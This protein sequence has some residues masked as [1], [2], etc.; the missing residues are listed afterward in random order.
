ML[1]AHSRC[2]R[3]N[4]VMKVRVE[5]RKWRMTVQPG[6]DLHE[7]AKFLLSGEVFHYFRIFLARIT[8]SQFKGHACTRHTHAHTHTNTHSE[9]CWDGLLSWGLYLEPAECPFWQGAAIEVVKGPV[10]PADTLSCLVCPPSALQLDKICSFLEALGPSRRDCRVCQ[11]WCIIKCF[12]HFVT[13]KFHFIPGK[14][15][16]VRQRP[17]CLLGFC[18]ALAALQESSGNLLKEK[19]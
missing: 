12:I 18:G 17:A 13:Q 7:S 19:K 4:K 5:T 16:T 3:F 2:G 15:L 10:S 9:D 14:S 6:S 8:H 1:P 11:S